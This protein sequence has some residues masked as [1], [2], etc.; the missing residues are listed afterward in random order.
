MP[1]RVL[2]AVIRL[3][4]V[5]LIDVG[6]ACVSAD[7]RASRDRGQR[8]ETGKERDKRQ[9]PE[10]APIMTRYHRKSSGHQMANSPRKKAIGRAM[11]LSS[12]NENTSPKKPLPAVSR[13]ARR[14]PL[15]SAVSIVLRLQRTFFVPS[16]DVNE[17]TSSSRVVWSEQAAPFR[18]ESP[19]RC[20]AASTEPKIP[21]S[22]RCGFEVHGSASRA[23]PKP[24]PPMP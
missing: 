19:K 13:A 4:E 5:R 23:S 11:A 24:I 16:A 22:L 9:P 12:T 21:P 17:R 18:P 2:E 8:H 14:M 10:H 1:L 7:V 6:A 3:V 20:T 15:R